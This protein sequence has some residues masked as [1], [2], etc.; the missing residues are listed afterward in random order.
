M[1]AKKSGG[2]PIFPTTATARLA[3]PNRLAMPSL[4]YQALHA[5]RSEQHDAYFSLVT[6]YGRK[7]RPL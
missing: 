1:E 7:G 6:G 4:A 3:P 5:L 2:F